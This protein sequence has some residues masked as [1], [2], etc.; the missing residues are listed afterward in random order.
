MV[1]SALEIFT[2]RENRIIDRRISDR[3]RLGLL[4]GYSVSNVAAKR[5]GTWD[6]V[7]TDHRAV[8]LDAPQNLRLRKAEAAKLNI[9]FNDRNDR[10]FRC[11]ENVFVGLLI[12][13]VRRNA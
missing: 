3:R 13:R 2:R 4:Q 9:T 12:N 6:S 8:L 11:S 5:Q 1:S 7:G 10:C